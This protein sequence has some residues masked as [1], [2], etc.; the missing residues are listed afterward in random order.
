MVFRYIVL[1]FFIHFL[2]FLLLLIVYD[3][4]IAV[5]SERNRFL[6]AL[7]SFSSV[8]GRLIEFRFLIHFTSTLD[9]VHLPNTSGR[10]WFQCSWVDIQSTKL[11]IQRSSLQLLWSRLLFLFLWLL[12]FL[13]LLKHRYL[14]FGRRFL[15]F[16]HHCFLLA[17]L[18]DL[19]VFQLVL[20]QIDNI[21]KL[22]LC[23]ASL[24][25]FDILSNL[26]HSIANISH[27]ELDTNRHTHFSPKRELCEFIARL[28]DKHAFLC[29][30]RQV[31]AGKLTRFELDTILAVFVIGHRL[32]KRMIVVFGACDIQL[33]AVVHHAEIFVAFHVLQ[34]DALVFIAAIK[35]NRPLC[36]L[37]TVAFLAE[38]AFIVRVHSQTLTKT[39]FDDHCLLL[40]DERVLLHK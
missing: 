6:F 7:L 40:L 29:I 28:A 10:A 12:L 19:H 34:T 38:F 3:L 35:L 20:F 15:R 23:I 31:F 8:N 1:L 11:G 21:W 32:E 5:L 2:L 4:D 33:F 16:L 30:H 18:Y 14:I 22:C 9:G 39:M 36:V 26:L 24:F 37:C 13:L 17:L 27:F 25:A